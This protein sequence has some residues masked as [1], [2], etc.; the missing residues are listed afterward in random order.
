MVDFSAHVTRGAWEIRLSR[1]S[2]TS[3]SNPA[4]RR[5]V[6][7]TLVLRLRCVPSR[8]DG[9]A[10]NSNCDVRG[11]WSDSACID[12]GLLER[13]TDAAA[14]H[15]PNGAARRQRRAEREAQWG[16]ERSGVLGVLPGAERQPNDRDD[17]RDGRHQRGLRDR[18][19]RRR[20]RRQSVFHRC[21]AQRHERPRR[22]LRPLWE[23]GC[24]ADELHSRRRRRE[25]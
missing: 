15:H 18:R 12:V 14:G 11:R 16:A 7:L 24:R 6:F 1:V 13:V 5:K 25:L 22:R 3:F 2:D 20:L 4:I 19:R 10:R 17:P 9:H 23:E 21:D 8:G